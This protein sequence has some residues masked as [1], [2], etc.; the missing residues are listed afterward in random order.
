VPRNGLRGESQQY[1]FSDKRP[2]Q[3]TLEHIANEEEFSFTTT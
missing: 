3:Y 1:A 2:A